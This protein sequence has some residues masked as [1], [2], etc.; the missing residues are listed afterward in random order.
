MAGDALPR[1][2]LVDDQLIRN[3]GDQAVVVEAFCKRRGP[4]WQRAKVHRRIDRSA[5]VVIAI[6]IMLHPAFEVGD[7]DLPVNLPEKL[8]MFRLA[9]VI[10]LRDQSR[11]S[12]KGL[13]VGIGHAYIPP[14]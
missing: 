14:R 2:I 6:T 13:F 12:I 3:G 5:L 9:E 11:D 7:P 1:F 4:G 8:V 10:F